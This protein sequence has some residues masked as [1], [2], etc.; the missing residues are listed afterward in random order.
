VR[1]YYFIAELLIV[2][3]RYHVSFCTALMSVCL[4]TWVSVCFFLFVFM[5]FIGFVA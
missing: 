4:L 3:Y 2:E 1:K 5:M